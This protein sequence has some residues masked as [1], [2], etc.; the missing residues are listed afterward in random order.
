MF[1]EQNDQYRVIQL[2]HWHYHVRT[3]QHLVEYKTDHVFPITPSTPSP[4]RFVEREL[5]VIKR[6]QNITSKS[7]FSINIPAIH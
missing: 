5:V 1:Q 6:N 7:V 3:L 2:W 4:S